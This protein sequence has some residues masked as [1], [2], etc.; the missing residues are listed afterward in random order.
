MTAETRCVVLEAELSRTPSTELPLRSIALV[1]VVNDVEDDTIKLKAEKGK[2]AKEKSNLI[3]ELIEARKNVPELKKLKKEKE[4]YGEERLKLYRDLKEAHEWIEELENLLDEADQQCDKLKKDIEELDDEEEELLKKKSVVV[5]E[6]DM[7]KRKLEEKERSGEL[8]LKKIGELTAENRRFTERLDEAK[9]RI[10]VLNGE[11]LKLEQ[12]Q[13]KRSSDSN[14]AA[15][16]CEEPKK[17]KIEEPDEKPQ[18][19]ESK[20]QWKNLF[21][22]NRALSG[23]YMGIPPATVHFNPANA[24]I[25]PPPPPP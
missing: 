21:E 19:T 11:K 18:I 15:S 5:R 24:F 9:I 20:L 2:L 1:P 17:I 10:E 13:K 25:L 6:L 14:I 4:E 3:Q 22:T 16:Q 23:P 12:N 7:V 8:N